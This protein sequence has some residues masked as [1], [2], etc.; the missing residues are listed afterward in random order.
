MKMLQLGMFLLL[1]YA[2]I[3]KHQ[4]GLVPAIFYGGRY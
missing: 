1:I 2:K 4:R 3:R